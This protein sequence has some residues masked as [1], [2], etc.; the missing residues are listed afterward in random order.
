ML[1]ICR[2]LFSHSPPTPTL[3]IS[4]GRFPSS[5]ATFNLFRWHYK[6][7]LPIRNCWRLTISQD[8]RRWRAN[9]MTSSKEKHI[10]TKRAKPLE[11]WMHHV[12]HLL[13][14]DTKVL[15]RLI[16]RK[17][18]GAWSNGRLGQVWAPILPKLIDAWTETPTTWYPLGALLPVAMQYMKR[19]TNA[20]GRASEWVTFFIGARLTFVSPTGLCYWYKNVNPLELS[21]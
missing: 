11:S 12:V 10:L 7:S 2:F 21:I 17:K 8:R 19:A 6:P 15:E 5:M 3:T 9:E 4:S 1:K 13:D 14:T 20:K 16:C 18:E